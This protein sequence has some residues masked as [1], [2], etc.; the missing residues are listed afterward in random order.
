[1]RTCL[2]S[3]DPAQGLNLI[4]V[5]ATNAAQG[6]A[7]LML[8]LLSESDGRVLTHSDSSWS[9]VSNGCRY[10]PPGMCSLDRSVSARVSRPC[11]VRLNRDPTIHFLSDV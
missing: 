8:A 1:M 7:G 5:E 11:Q 10:C 3:P 9:Y 4:E 2:A 6:P